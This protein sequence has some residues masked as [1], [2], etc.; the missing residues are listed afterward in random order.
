MDKNL[1]RNFLWHLRY[2]ESLLDASRDGNITEESAKALALGI[3]QTEF[4]L[5]D[6]LKGGGSSCL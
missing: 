2:T 6:I 4:I 1:H 3:E 5:T